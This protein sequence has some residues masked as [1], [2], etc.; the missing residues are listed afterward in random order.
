MLKDSLTGFYKESLDRRGD[1]DVTR[2]RAR[3]FD[4]ARRCAGM[5]AHHAR[6]NADGLYRD[7]HENV[8]RRIGWDLGNGFHQ[9][10]PDRSQSRG[11]GHW[12]S[13]Q[14]KA[15]DKRKRI[16]YLTNHGK[17]ERRVTVGNRACARMVVA[18]RKGKA[19]DIHILRRLPQ[20]VVVAIPASLA[21]RYGNKTEMVFADWRAASRAFSKELRRLERAPMHERWGTCPLKEDLTPLYQNH[22]KTR[23]DDGGPKRFKTF[24]R[25]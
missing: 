15:I 6:Q 11:L 22:G 14:N 10:G 5:Y 23:R 1:S 12:P 16:V 2:A 17:A 19:M 4:S 21:G 9:D 24:A 25:L 20:G 8:I 18:Y 3:L 7:I 13:R